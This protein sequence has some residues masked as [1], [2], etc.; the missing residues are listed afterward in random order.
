MSEKQAPYADRL[1]QARH[2]AVA[3]IAV[4]MLPLEPQNP[5]KH[6]AW[7]IEGITERARLAWRDHNEPN[8]YQCATREMRAKPHIYKV[9]PFSRMEEDELMQ[10]GMQRAEKMPAGST[11]PRRYGR[12]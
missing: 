9:K 5:P 11:R 1:K 12:D 3:S 8:S 10:Q 4:C 7:S 2:D 6:S